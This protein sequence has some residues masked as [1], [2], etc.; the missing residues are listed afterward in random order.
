M[1]GAA[2]A[3]RRLLADIDNNDCYKYATIRNI[4]YRKGKSVEMLV[5]YDPAFAMM[6]E[7]FKQLFGESEGK[8]DK[9]LFPSAATFSTDLHSLGQFIQDGSKVMFETVIAH[10]DSQRATSSWSLT[11][12]IL[13]DLTSSQIRICQL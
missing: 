9:G 13:M 11:R 4:L 12:I 7:W 10:Q 5:A 2:K 8:D 1:A 6:G 3:M